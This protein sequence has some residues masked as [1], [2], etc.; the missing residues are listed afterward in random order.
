MTFPIPLLRA[1]L[2]PS[3][4]WRAV[5]LRTRATTTA[6][7]PTPLLKAGST[8]RLESTSGPFELVALL[9]K[10][11]LVIYLDR[12]ESNDPVCR[13]DRYRRNA[14]R[15]SSP[16]MPR[17]V[18]IVWRPPGPAA[19]SHDLIFTVTADDVTEILSGV[20]KVARRLPERS[21][22][23]AGAFSP[24]IAQGIKETFGSGGTAPAWYCWR[25]LPASAATLLRARGKEAVPVYS[26]R[27]HPLLFAAGLRRSARRTRSRYRTAAAADRRTGAAVSRRLR[28]SCP[29]RCSASWR[30]ARC[31]PRCPTHRKSLELP[32]RIIPDPNASGF[33]QASVSGRLSPPE[34]GFPK[35]R[36][37]RE[38]G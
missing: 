13:G 23:A 32:G 2:S 20:L 6:A 30:S 17:K 11:E 22:A 29:S 8:P 28:C 7:K 26:R 4:C 18:R 31:S 37:G 24:A 9:Q 33:V 10:G 12:F 5:R 34:G 25:L 14:G 16:P 27:I 38:G 15:F 1:T 3:H 19:G 35:A 21:R 36:H